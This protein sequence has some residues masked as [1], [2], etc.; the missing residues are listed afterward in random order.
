[1]AKSGTF[2]IGKNI[3]KLRE[4][5]GYSQQY[6]AD[7]LDITQ[8]TYSN[9]EA[10]DG[11]VNKG[12]IEHIAQ[13]LEVDPAYLL[14]YDDKIVFNNTDCNDMFNTY[15]NAPSSK[16]RELYE[17]RIEEQKMLYEQMMAKLKEENEFLKSLVRK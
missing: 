6:M 7:Q 13:I 4:F 17:T 14:T 5:R 2:E 10:D 8:K 12:Q 11:K 15:H 1:M 3:K 9:I 16:E